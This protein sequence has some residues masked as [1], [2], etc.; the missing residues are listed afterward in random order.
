MRMSYIIY[1]PLQRVKYIMGTEIATVRGSFWAA[2]RSYRPGYQNP[3]NI[4]NRYR[5]V[6]TSAVFHVVDLAMIFLLAKVDC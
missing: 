5:G 2:Q 6:R 4:C 1:I 3:R